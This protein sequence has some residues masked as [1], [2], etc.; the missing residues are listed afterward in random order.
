M[1]THGTYIPALRFPFL[2]RF[3]DPIVRVLLKD[4]KFRRR[5]IAEADIQHGQSVLDIGCGTGTL[6]LL[7]KQAVPSAKI[8]GIDA[9]P[10]ILSLARDKAVRAGADILFI[11]GFA[12]AVPLPSESYDRVVSSL[13]F[14]HMSTD[15]KRGT[16]AEVFRLLR[17]L[18]DRVG[19]PLK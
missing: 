7:I 14:H 18:R 9:D 4:E 15:S 1:K 11:E 8:A 17:Y 13:A 6:A 3:F 16:L 2:T 12:D 5:L 10:S 19:A